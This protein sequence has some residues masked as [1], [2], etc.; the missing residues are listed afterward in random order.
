MELKTVF[1]VSG[2]VYTWRVAINA[3]EDLAC[4]VMLF[5]TFCSQPSENETTSGDNTARH[6]FVVEA[7][8]DLRIQV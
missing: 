1:M 8:A 4:V 5:I 3:A 2:Y 6:N 7:N